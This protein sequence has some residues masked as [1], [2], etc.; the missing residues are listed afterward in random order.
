N[1]EQHQSHPAIDAY[2]LGVVIYYLLTGRFPDKNN[3]L[4]VQ[5]LRRRIPESLRQM[6]SQLMSPVVEERPSAHVVAQ[7]L[8]RLYLKSGTSDLDTVSTRMLSAFRDKAN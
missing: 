8:N 1:N 2:A 5:K 4:P 7:G 3:P 6:L